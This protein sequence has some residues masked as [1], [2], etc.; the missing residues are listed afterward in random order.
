MPEDFWIDT[1]F[2]KLAQL[3]FSEN[4]VKGRFKC[5][6]ILRFGMDY[7]LCAEF[8][9]YVTKSIKEQRFRGLFM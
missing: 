1:I 9:S 8:Q 6:I 5:F 3:F 4:L 2:G 7:S